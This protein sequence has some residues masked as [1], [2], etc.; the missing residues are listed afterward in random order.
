MNAIEGDIAFLIV[1]S[2]ALFFTW[3]FRKWK[4]KQK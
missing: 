2:I 1:M 3:V 4:S